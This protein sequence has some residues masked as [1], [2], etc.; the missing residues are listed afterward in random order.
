MSA[1]EP[2]CRVVVVELNI[3]PTVKAVAV[4]AIR[5]ATLCELLP[6]HVLVTCDAFH[7]QIL[8]ILISITMIIIIIL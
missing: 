6:V 4:L 1:I 3:S 8:E 5:Y 7:G 2:E